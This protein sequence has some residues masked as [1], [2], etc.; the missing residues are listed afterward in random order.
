MI[1]WLVGILIISFC[2]VMTVQLLRLVYD[3]E[4]SKLSEESPEFV[5]ER[6]LARTG[7]ESS[8]DIFKGNE[9]VG[10]LRLE[11]IPL[12]P[13]EKRKSGG[14]ARLRTVGLLEMPIPGRG[15]SRLAL[16]S[17]MTLDFAATVKE[18]DLTLRLDEMGIS[19]RLLQPFGNP[20]PQILLKQNDTI[21]LDSASLGASSNSTPH[22]MMTLLFSGL[23]IDAA[24]I[25]RREQAL[26]SEVEATKTSARRGKFTV[27][28]RDFV[29]YKLTTTLGSP[30]RVCTLYIS[31]SGEVIEMKT[32]FL[33]YQF[34]SDGLRPDGIIGIEVKK[35]RPIAP[36]KSAPPTP[37]LK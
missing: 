32:N 25:Q 33:D 14:E 7:V 6:F 37:A 15:K 29:G 30:D 17:S 8:L 12:L 13:N 23:G 11:P 16:E 3:P 35:N 31:D 24:E 36:L 20:S 28:E 5:M 10:Y 22:G 1:R 9:L 19:L 27:R 2:G 21:L 4:D 18:S 34:I 26:K